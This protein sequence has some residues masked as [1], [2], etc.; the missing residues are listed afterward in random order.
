M[1]SDYSRMSRMPTGDVRCERELN[2]QRLTTS[3]KGTVKNVVKKSRESFSLSQTYYSL[4][5]HRLGC[6]K[7]CDK[8]ADLRS[9][10]ENQMAATEY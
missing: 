1:F 6:M 7:E 10:P 9:R 3:E 5:I 4:E 2:L 8:E